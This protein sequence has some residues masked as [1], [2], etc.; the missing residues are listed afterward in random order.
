MESFVQY[1]PS[2][3]FRFLHGCWRIIYGRFHNEKVTHVT[4]VFITPQ[5]FGLEQDRQCTCTCT[6][7]VT[8]RRVRATVVVVGK[9]CVL[10]ILSVCICNLSYPACNVYEPCC[11]LWS[12]RLYSIFS[13]LSH[14][15]HDFRKKCVE[16]KMFVLISSTTFV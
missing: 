5:Q 8:M 1:Y 4:A 14:K 12:A 11:H 2:T 3:R 16:Y 15:R 9:Q 13:T 10:Y 6:C 7:N